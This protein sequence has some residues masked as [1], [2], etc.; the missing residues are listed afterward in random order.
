[1]IDVIEG[2]PASFVLPACDGTATEVPRDRR[3]AN[4]SSTGNDLT[5]RKV[6]TPSQARH[7]KLSGFR[8]A[9]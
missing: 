6:R 1:M 5:R 4:R 9:K 7:G 8:Q 2:C 3:P